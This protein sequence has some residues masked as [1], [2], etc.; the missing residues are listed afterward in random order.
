LEIEIKLAT[1]KDKISQIRGLYSGEAALQLAID[2]IETQI[3]NVAGKTQAMVIAQTA[4]IKMTS[5]AQCI[6][7]QLPI[8]DLGGLFEKF[9]GT[10]QGLGECKFFDTF[11][12]F[13]GGL[14]VPLS[15]ESVLAQLDGLAGLVSAK[16]DDLLNIEGVFAEF[17]DLQDQMKSSLSMVSS[18]VGC[19]DGAGLDFGQ[20]LSS[21][22]TIMTETNPA[23]KLGLDA[24]AAAKTN[25]SNPIE[26]LNDAK[27]R[28]TGALDLDG[29]AKN[30]KA[31]FE[32]GLGRLT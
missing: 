1:A 2:A 13:L 18:L 25:F 10:I 26:I 31:Q 22:D 7:L 29:Q 19:V 21:L 32:N 27:A 12:D 8:P 14:T 20:Q 3:E 30:L 9:I 24:I 11:T 4:G 17:A 5:A 28:V 6:G 23:F 16:I 15:I